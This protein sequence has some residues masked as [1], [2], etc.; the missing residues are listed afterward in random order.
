M[1][2]AGAYSYL[3]VEEREA[4]VG[5]YRARTYR[6]PLA[7]TLRRGLLEYPHIVE[8]ARA[9]TVVLKPNLVEYHER[10]GA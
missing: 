4:R 6:E 7:D 9:G 10:A 1:V 5:I 8:K 2:A 3:H